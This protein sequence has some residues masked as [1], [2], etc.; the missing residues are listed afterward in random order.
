MNM[1]GQV[2]YT[3]L[4]GFV[5]RNGGD[6][7]SGFFLMWLPV[8]SNDVNFCMI[9]L[10]LLFKLGTSF[11]SKSIGPKWLSVSFGKEGFSRIARGCHP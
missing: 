4:N 10:L 7:N 11:P 9:L 1:Q 3:I 5:S 2:E 6:T 8:T